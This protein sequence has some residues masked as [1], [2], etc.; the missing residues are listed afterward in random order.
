MAGVEANAPNFVEL[1]QAQSMQIIQVVQGMAALLERMTRR[2]DAPQN[3]AN[4]DRPKPQYNEK[5][6]GKLF[7]KVKTF[8]GGEEEWTE[9][10]EDLRLIVDMKSSK[11]AKVMKH[12]ELHGEKA[13]DKAVKDLVEEDVQEYHQN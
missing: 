10:S 13:V 4:Q 8:T 6:D 2:E 3:E 1:F 7:E 5:L 12:V 11:L 9:W